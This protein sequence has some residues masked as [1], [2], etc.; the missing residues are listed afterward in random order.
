MLTPCL[1]TT[2]NLFQLTGQQR[3]DTACRVNLPG[4]V[5]ASRLGSRESKRNWNLLEKDNISLPTVSNWRSNLSWAAQR[6]GD[7][8]AMARVCSSGN[9]NR[10]Q[11]TTD[12]R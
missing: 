6:T 11:V 9:T 1:E 7:Q 2:T 12:D 5:L 8:L 10:S 4:P 3:D